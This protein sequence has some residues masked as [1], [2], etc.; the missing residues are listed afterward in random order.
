MSPSTE[1]CSKHHG[2]DDTS[3]QPQPI[4]SNHHPAP[5]PAF[6]HPKSQGFCN[7]FALCVIPQSFCTVLLPNFRG[8]HQ[9]SYCYVRSALRHVWRHALSCL[10]SIGGSAF[11]S[12][13]CSP[14]LKF[15]PGMKGPGSRLKRDSCAR[16]EPIHTI[17]SATHGLEV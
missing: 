12:T 7:V 2:K 17:A 15:N 6:C 13:L 3:E 16:Q 14:H 9:R 11:A 8:H 1:R 10:C 5:D 4:T